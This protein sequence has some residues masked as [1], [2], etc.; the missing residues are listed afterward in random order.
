M[1]KDEYIEHEVKLRL[2]SEQFKIQERNFN[3][4]KHSFKALSKELHDQFKWT[5]GTMIAL[6]GGLIITKFF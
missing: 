5:V 3:E 4:L 2:H 1:T 6:F